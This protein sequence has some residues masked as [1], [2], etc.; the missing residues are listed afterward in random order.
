MKF[1]FLWSKRFF[2]EKLFDNFPIKNSFNDKLTDRAMKFSYLHQELLWLLLII[3]FISSISCYMTSHEGNYDKRTFSSFSLTL[4]PL[5]PSFVVTAVSPTTYFSLSI[6]PCL[7]GFSKKRFFFL[8]ILFSHLIVIVR[9]T[10]KL[11]DNRG[12]KGEK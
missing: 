4:P 3:H 1:N 2:I 10:N 9:Y 12:E 8:F 5:P 7:L 6:F 11:E